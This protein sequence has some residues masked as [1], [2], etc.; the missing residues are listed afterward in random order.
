MFNH[1]ICLKN[2]YIIYLKRK[3]VYIAGIWLRKEI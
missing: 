2:I 1:M 3:K